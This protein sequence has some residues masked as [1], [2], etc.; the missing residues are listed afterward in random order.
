MVIRITCYGKG[1]DG[2]KRKGLVQEGGCRMQRILGRSGSIYSPNK[3]FL[4]T[5]Y[6][7]LTV[8]AFK[9]KIMNNG[10]AVGAVGTPVKQAIAI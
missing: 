10:E 6:V 2:E 4:S 5:Y 3:Y 8:I 1:R 9:G 7:L